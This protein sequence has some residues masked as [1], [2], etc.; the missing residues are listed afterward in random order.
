MSAVSRH[1]SDSSSATAL[2][3][4]AERRARIRE[5]FF[6]ARDGQACVREQSA[7][8]DVLVT[9]AWEH[10]FG[11][12]A[13]GAALIAVGGYGRA[14]LF[15]SSDVDVLVVARDSR[16][17]TRIR[18]AVRDFTQGLW[19]A[20]LRVSATTRT[21]E[22]C[23]RLNPENS[24]FTFALLDARVLSGDASLT[25]QFTQTTLPHMFARERIPLLRRLVEL[26]RV[27]HEKYGGTIFHLE[28]NVKET[29]GML[30][31]LHVA[32]WLARLLPGSGKPVELGDDALAAHRFLTSVR[33]FLHYR[34]G[35]D[36]NT[37]Y[38]PAQDEAA[39]AGIGVESA[40]DAG[41]WMRSCFRHARHVQRLTI[42][43]LKDAAAESD[44]VYQQMKRWRSQPR[45]DEYRVRN[46]QIVP[47]APLSED[48]PL[49]VLQMFRGVARTGLPLS[50]AAEARVSELLP[51]ISEALDPA[52]LWEDSRAL[53]LERHAA[54]AL[55]AMHSIGVLE[56]L[57]PEF[58]GIDA[59]V[60]RDAWHRY[61][62]DEHTFILLDAIARL[63]EMRPEA[64]TAN[65]DEMFA[66]LYRELDRPELLRFAALMHDTG[67][68]HRG[69]HH[70]GTSAEL[71]DA[72]LSRWNVAPEDRAI[73]RRLI[74][75]H[76]AMS[77][78]LRRDIFDAGTVQAVAD[79]AKT[80]ELLRMLTLL[81]WA[82]IQAVHPD[83]L[84]PF[85]A[86]NLWQLYIATSN[87]LD[88]SLDQERIEA[89][90]PADEPEDA[91]RITAILTANKELG[92]A[93]VRFLNGLPRRYLRTHSRAS[94]GEHCRMAQRLGAGG[95]QIRTH[96]IG[97]GF[98][99]SIVT[100]D[101]PHLFANIA[102]G[103]AAQGMNILKAEA[104]SNAAGVVVDTF[105]FEDVYGTLEQNPGEIARFEAKLAQAI[106]GESAMASQLASRQ[107][108][109]R[110]R[111]RKRAIASQISFD[112][113]SSTQST[114]LQVIAPDTPGL[115]YT[116]SRVLADHDCDIGTALIDTEGE[117][118]ID[119]FYLTRARA[120]L[121][122]EQE[123]D[124]SASLREAVA[125]M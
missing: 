41:L 123:N 73:V 72:A 92:L 76:L 81:T 91:A 102:G 90:S 120:R 30:R 118:A 61:T 111:P 83:A 70:A 122:A 115:L 9:K 85:K 3:G 93:L 32:A 10:T 19:D 109:R 52:S 65:R 95:L 105:R 87:Y 48:S 12:H 84:T 17:E 117:Q 88:R 119:V 16:A 125:S 77:T 108:A 86:E 6:K 114:V 94:I 36:D 57:L 59:L 97:G 44:S 28:P 75:Y 58:H 34:A 96:P 4:F 29:P 26:S 104:F 60:V 13:K 2:P 82:D 116:L 42:G 63:A 67:K 112:D 7:D 99:V 1:S 56:L 113:T 89:A 71:A 24:E 8:V 80:P 106:A 40:A 54:E 5:Y 20:G 22:E 64:K 66:T 55:R 100:T 14:E 31:D 49:A 98:E 124:L 50:R 53:L 69:D 79:A 74:R 47:A 21:T 78:A 110:R 68:G 18:G 46:A 35:R 27:R 51:Y 45:T 38:W 43:L 11:E 107:Q 39:A 121:T 101:R 103:L 15:P 25:A 37:L 23:A 33:C 62:V